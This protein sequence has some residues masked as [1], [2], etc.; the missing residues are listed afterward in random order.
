MVVFSAQPARVPR[1]QPRVL[2]RLLAVPLVFFALEALVF[3]TG[4]YLPYLEPF[5]MAGNLQ[6]RLWDEEKRFYAG[7]YEV[8]AVGDSRMGFRARV[9][10]QLTAETGYTFAT[11]AIPGTTPRC[12]YY[13]LREVDPHVNRYSAVIIAVNDYDESADEAGRLLDLNYLV[14]ILRCPDIPE[15]TL[16]F[17]NWQ[18]RWLAFRGSLLKGLFFKNDF[19]DFLVNHKKRMERLQWD[20]ESGAS[21][22][23]NGVWGTRDVAGLSVDWKAGK[24]LS[25]PDWM[26]ADQRQQTNDILLPP[27]MPASDG[28][29]YGRKWFGKIVDRYRGTSTRIIFIQLPRGPVVRPWSLWPRRGP[30]RRLA[31]EGTTLLANQNAFDSVERPDLFGDAM[32][33]NHPGAERFSVLLAREVRRLLG[34]PSR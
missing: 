3:R 21:I 25:Y 4:V 6:R 32:H 33:M 26:D 7:S 24:I 22:V 19:Q 1:P 13:M 11:I 12:W 9:A 27:F 28:G 8:I 34:P 14:P 20:R 17:D 23:Y 30:I 18:A 31:A 29:A 10:N 5:A 15:F 2:V 16:S